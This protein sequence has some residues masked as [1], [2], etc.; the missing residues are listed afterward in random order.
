MPFRYHDWF[1]SMIGGSE[2]E[3]IIRS[4]L[5][6]TLPPFLKRNL[7]GN[8]EQEHVFHLFLSYLYDAGIINAYQYPNEALANALARTHETWQLFLQDAGIANP[9]C[10][11]VLTNGRMILAM[12]S[13][14]DIMGYKSITGLKGCPYCRDHSHGDEGA[15]DHIDLRA[16]FLMADLDLAPQEF[17]LA[18]LPSGKLLLF[19][20]SQPTLLNK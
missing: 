8:S 11:F 14:D 20:G 13:H 9:R 2:R 12:A 1:F 18:P 17:G 10:A 19:D 7:R 4:W 15:K 6:G 5:S 16:T 3:S